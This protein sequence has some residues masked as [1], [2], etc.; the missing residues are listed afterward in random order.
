MTPRMLLSGSR[1]ELDRAVEA[2]KKQRMKI[3]E[4]KIEK[5]KIICGF[6]GE[7]HL[8]VELLGPLWFLRRTWTL[9]QA[10]SKAEIVS[11]FWDDN[12]GGAKDTLRT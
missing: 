1:N 2:A 3:H 10:L 7:G 12:S 6:C 8:W 11:E 5:D 9:P 4:E